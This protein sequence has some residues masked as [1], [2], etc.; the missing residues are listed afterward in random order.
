VNRLARQIITVA[1]AL[2]GLELWR[3]FLHAQGADLYQ[4]KVL[5]IAA[6][7]ALLPPIHRRLDKYIRYCD[8]WLASH[9]GVVAVV[10]GLL[11]L[12]YFRLQAWRFTELLVAAVHDEHVYLIQAHM[13]AHGRLWHS[14]YPPQVRQFFDTFYLIMDRVYAPEYFPGTALLMVPATWLGW[15]FWSTTMVEASI[16]A[17]LLFLVSSEILATPRA[18]GAAPVPG[19]VRGIVAVIMLLSLKFF[20]MIALMPL[21]QGAF[22]M[23]ELLMLWT[24]L[25]WRRGHGGRWAPLVGAAGGLAAI[26]RPLDALCF[27]IPIAV[28]IVFELLR[29]PNPRAALGRAV[30][31]V[32]LGAAPF[33]A[34]QVIQDVGITGTWYRFPENVDYATNYPAPIFGFHHVDP[35]KL[36]R[37][38][39]EQR[40]FWLHWVVSEYYLKHDFWHSSRWLPER[41]RQTVIDTIPNAMLVVLAPL[42]LLSLRGV[43]RWVMFGSLMLFLVSY[44]VYVFDLEHY[45]V[46]ITPGMIV[47]LLL[48]WESL[49]GAS[50]LLRPAVDGFMLVAV[51]GISL[52][53]LPFFDYGI[54][55][56]IPNVAEQ[57]ISNQILATLP[58]TPAVVLF[59]YDPKTSS[60]HNELIYNDAVAWPDD[61]TIVRASD[62]GE[63]ENWKLYAYYASHQPDRVFYIYDRGALYRG[64][65]PLSAPLGT[66]RELAAAHEPSRSR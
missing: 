29:L 42:G 10:V 3:A 66:A 4:R 18:P 63:G 44:T 16:T 28:A 5:A 34:L 57:F 12:G 48:G 51:L 59:R 24:W 27:A 54:R 61:A 20:R 19:H 43:R 46:V 56:Y 62:L 50:A 21:S 36:P 11:V 9:R 25:R 26:I 6:I 22:L 13:L 1:L 65:D 35:D 55:F 23:A 15:P 38:T 37:P 64:R 58:R 41:L 52:L 32:I 17:L 14:P 45:P 7:V 53:A 60:F 30:A 2:L 8:A 33:L 47:L 39:S 31:L 49:A 40:K